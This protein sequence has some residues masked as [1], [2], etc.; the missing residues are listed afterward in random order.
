MMTIIMIIKK[1]VMFI[2]TL[3]YNLDLVGSGE[4]PLNLLIENKLNTTLYNFTSFSE[5]VVTHFNN[6]AI[7][8]KFN[9][10]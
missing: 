8:F 10:I 6:V 9:P 5:S 2:N 7:V 1:K 4:N 3:I